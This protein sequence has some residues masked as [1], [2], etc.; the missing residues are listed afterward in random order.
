MELNLGLDFEIN[1]AFV[2]MSVGEI[3]GLLLNEKDNLI[4]NKK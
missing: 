1:V 2:N 4:S 3:M